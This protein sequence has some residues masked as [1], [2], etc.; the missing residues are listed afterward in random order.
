MSL[1][2]H[3][4]E[5]HTSHWLADHSVSEEEHIVEIRVHTAIL[6]LNIHQ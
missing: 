4:V 2:G 1:Q 6:H 3:S 5:C